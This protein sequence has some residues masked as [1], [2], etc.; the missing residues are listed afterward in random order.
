MARQ[1]RQAKPETKRS[2]DNAN[3]ET[4]AAVGGLATEAAAHGAALKDD[5]DALLDEIDG[6]LEEN[7]EEFVRNYLQKG[8]E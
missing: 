8:G 1:E 7:A 2:N 3:E 6:V 4:V 5:M